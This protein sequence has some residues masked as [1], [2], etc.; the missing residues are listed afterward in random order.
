MVK[1]IAHN[2]NDGGSTPSKHKYNILKKYYTEYNAAVAYLF[3]EQK[4]V[5]SNLTIL[6]K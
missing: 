6:K 2:D 1:H 4:V 3:W 5:S